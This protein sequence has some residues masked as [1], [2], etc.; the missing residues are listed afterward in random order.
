MTCIVGYVEKGN[1]WIGGDSAGVGGYSIHARA[2]EKVFKKEEMIFGFTSS[3]RMGQVIRY[4]L[5]IPEQ[6]SKKDAFTFLCSDFIDALIKCFK[7]KAFVQIKDSVASGGTF[8]LGYKENLYTIYGDF[9]VAKVLDSY[10]AV[11][12]GFDLALGAMHTLNHKNCPGTLTPEKKITLALEAATHFSA[13]V[14]PPFNIV[15]LN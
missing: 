9:Q 15:N 3:F 7:D 4:C 5:Q 12:C 1:V 11:G 2:D 6:S 14:C 8:L 10:A 13:G